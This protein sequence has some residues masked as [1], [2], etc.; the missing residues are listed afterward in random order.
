MKANIR[1]NKVARNAGWLITG[2]FLNKAIS[3]LVGIL[4]A[5]YLGPGNYGLIHYAT[6]YT[7]FFASLCSLGINNVIVNNLIDHPDEEGETI[8]TTLLLR[9]I[10]SLLSGIMIVGIVSIVDHGEKLTIVV[11]A[12]CCIG[13]LF[14]I[15]ETFNYWFQS[16]LESKYSAMAALLSYVLTSAYKLVLL[17][18]GKS[19]TWFALA[20]SV[21]YIALA[22]L[23]F[24]AYSRKNGP[25]L[26][27]SFRKAKQL[28]KSSSSFILTGMMISI[29]ASTDRF[30]LK[31][32]LGESDVGYYS[33]A[34]TI[35]VSWTFI[36]SAIIDSLYP[37]I[38]KSYQTDAIKFEHNNIRLYALVFYLS[39]AMSVC[40]CLLA[41]PIIVYIYGESYLPAISPLRVIVWYT[42]FSYLGVAR[43]A[44]LVCKKKQKYL[45][46]IYMSA[47][48]AN[49]LLNALLIPVWGTSGAAFA[50]LMAQIIT[51]M[52]TPFFIRQLRENSVMMVKAIFLQGIK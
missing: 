17:A 1:I 52:V 37:G 43:N 2:K 45:I 36:L 16:K 21:D 13:L 41:N 15:F 26:S 46:W 30:M 42:A 18:T 9:A 11:V 20:S 38:V 48:G 40:I 47:A 8:G 12:L 10:S 7:T 25:P 35:S 24:M 23:L 49:V 32:M 28:L 27:V 31:Q 50:S 29:Y 6:A 39:L 19:V 44:W 51:T 5:R 14:Q 4:A 34:S 3:F 22:L 33:L